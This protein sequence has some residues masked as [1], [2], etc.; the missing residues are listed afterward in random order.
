MYF[1]FV[2]I[3]RQG[4]KFVKLLLN[5]DLSLKYLSW[6]VSNIY[7]KRK[8]THSIIANMFIN[9]SRFFCSEFFT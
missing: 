3:V 5:F 1:Q 9:V 6:N 4:L 7:L 8:K 2:F